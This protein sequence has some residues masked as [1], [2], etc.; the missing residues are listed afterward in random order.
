MPFPKKNLNAN[1]TIA[2]DMHPHWWYFAEP[3][4]TLLG[5]IILAGLVLGETDGDTQK[6]LGWVMLIILVGTAIWLVVR[7]LKWL[8]TNFVI[9]SNRLIFRQGLIAKSGI[10]IPSTIWAISPAGITRLRRT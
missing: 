7:Y 10:E 8:T 6:S 1:E 4:L 9:T 3:A 5:A 2:L